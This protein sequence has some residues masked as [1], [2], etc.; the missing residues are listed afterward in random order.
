MKKLIMILLP[1]LFCAGMSF[2]QEGGA[3][4]KANYSSNFVLADPSYSDKILVLW[5]DFEENALDRHLDW[6]ADSVTMT[7]AEGATM[8]GKDQCLAGAKGARG[9]MKDYKASVDAWVSLKSTDRGQNVVC[10]WGN[11]DFT[12]QDGKH[13]NRR[14]QE[15]WGFNKD[16]KIDFM[17]QYSGLNGM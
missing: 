6:F 11:E 3:P 15:V 2:A 13:V 1:A 9:A 14:V 5:K 8:K 17:L 12:D 10:I 4:Y 7:V 16:G